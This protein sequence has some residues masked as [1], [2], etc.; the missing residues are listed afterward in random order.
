MCDTDNCDGISC[1]KRHPKSCRYFEIFGRC[2]Y[3]P[4]S[5]SHVAGSL[6]YEKLGN[7]ESLVDVMKREINVLK[8]SLKMNEEKT[9]ELEFQVSRCCSQEKH[10]SIIAA[11]VDGSGTTFIQPRRFT[12]TPMGGHTTTTT[13][14]SGALLPFWTKKGSSCCFHECH[15]DDKPPG[16]CCY[17]RCRE[18]WD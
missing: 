15:P 9:K 12:N 18:L 13:G 1:E 10:P 16:K 6:V 11:S 17:H 8:Q 3:N 14:R 2:K 5:Y 7:L 4:C